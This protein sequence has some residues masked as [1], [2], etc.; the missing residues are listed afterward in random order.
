MSAVEAAMQSR[1]YYLGVAGVAI[2]LAALLTPPWVAATQRRF[3]LAAPLMVAVLTYAIVSHGCATSFAVR[4]VAI[5]AVAREAVSAVAALDLPRERCHIVFLDVEPAPE[6]NIYV[7]MD[8]I[9]KATSPD[10]DRVAHC[11]FEANYATWFHL[12]A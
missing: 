12:L 1:L 2:M 8:S 10:L 6:W 4:S 5:S 11:W 3:A 9:I 7:S